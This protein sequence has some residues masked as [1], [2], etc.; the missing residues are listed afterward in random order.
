MVMQAC[1]ACTALKQA[2]TILQ[3]AD[4]TYIAALAQVINEFASSTAPPSEE[5]MTSIA[6]ALAQNAGANNQYAA[7]GKYVDAL[8][9][10]VSVL[11]SQMGFTTDQAV[12]LATDKYV[13]PLG[14]T[15][16]AGVAAYVAA[17]LAALAAL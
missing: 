13:G 16:N 10:Y 9:Q 3:D 12:Q 7:A 5:Q 2:G 4:G 17:R 8:A 15:Q 6:N 1:D 11:N 14:Q